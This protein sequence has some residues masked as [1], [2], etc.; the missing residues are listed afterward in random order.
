MIY[1][2]YVYLYL[3]EYSIVYF[4]IC[5]T[6]NLF[7]HLMFLLTFFIFPCPPIHPASNTRTHI[8]TPS[9]PLP[10]EFSN[11]WANMGGMAPPYC[12][13]TGPP[14]G[15]PYWH[16]YWAPHY[17]QLVY[18]Q[19]MYTVQCTVVA[20]SHTSAYFWSSRDIR[21]SYSYSNLKDKLSG[22]S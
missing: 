9:P 17:S 13:P 16:P 21:Y 14:T 18:R 1:S 7:F 19:Y 12:P 15:S 2:M 5:F 8:I 20:P 3:A 6:Y 11:S 22:Q 4:C 10:T